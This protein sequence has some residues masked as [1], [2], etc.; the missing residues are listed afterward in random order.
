MQSTVVEEQTRLRLMYRFYTCYLG[1]FIVIQCTTKYSSWLYL[2]VQINNMKE[3]SCKD[4]GFDCGFITNENNSHFLKKIKEHL[5]S[6]HGV[7]YQ[8][9]FLQSIFKKNHRNLDSDPV[10]CDEYSCGIRLE[11][12]KFGNRNFP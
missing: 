10:S 3:F 7:T 9:S 4:L 1:L 5:K 12:W 11:K 2:Q 8:E 6:I